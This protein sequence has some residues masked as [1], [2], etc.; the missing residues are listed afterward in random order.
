MAAKVFKFIGIALLAVAGIAIVLSIVLFVFLAGVLVNNYNSTGWE[1]GF[2]CLFKDRVFSENVAAVSMCIYDPSVD[3]GIIEIPE[4]CGRYHVTA[5]GGYLGKGLPSPFWIEVEGVDTERY[6][7]LS[8]KASA[9]EEGETVND[10]IVYYDLTLKI[11]PDIR[12][13]YAEQA[14][15][16]DG[17]KM[18][19]VR[20]YVECDPDN[21]EF[22]SENGILYYKT[23]ENK[24]KEVRGFYYWNR[25]Y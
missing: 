1:E 4:Y 15:Q 11:G 20:V 12:S 21:Q 10:N 5:L 14:G 25:W 13:I 18:H 19:I 7:S 6:C 3:T 2:Y 17:E 8:E 22:Y 9:P 24:G 16:D 23:G